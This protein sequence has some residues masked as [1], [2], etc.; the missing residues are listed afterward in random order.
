[1]SVESHLAHDCCR[2]ILRSQSRS[3]RSRD[4]VRARNGAITATNRRGINYLRCPPRAIRP[5]CRTF[6]K[7]SAGKADPAV[8]VGE[9]HARH[10]SLAF[11]LESYARSLARW[12]ELAAKMSVYVMSAPLDNWHVHMCMCPHTNIYI[13]IKYIWLNRAKE[14]GR[15]PRTPLWFPLLASSLLQ[16]RRLVIV[17]LRQQS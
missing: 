5:C 1:M 16:R 17:H 3:R 14:L 2:S 10:V 11:Q 6:P 7:T 9:P 15:T 13:Y 4:Q 8:I 12:L